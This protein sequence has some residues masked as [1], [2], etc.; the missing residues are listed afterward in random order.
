MATVNPNPSTKL[1]PLLGVFLAVVLT[2]AAGLLLLDS[3]GGST[4][5]AGLGRLIATVQS[6]RAH[7]RV[8]LSGDA[9]AMEAL[10]GERL[11]I[12]LL[13][14]DLLQQR[15]LSDGARGLLNDAGAWQALEDSVARIADSGELLTAFRSERDSLLTLGPQLLA[16][17]GN[18]VSALSPAELET[19]QIQ[20]ERLELTVEEMQQSARALGT[21]GAVAASARRLGDA[22]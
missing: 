5:D 20:I 8:A 6:A 13:R 7:A 19:N 14:T 10:R 3:G 18:V 21:P 15:G 17:T 11:E 16:A 12:D 4:A 2:G 1:L 9:D 22:Q